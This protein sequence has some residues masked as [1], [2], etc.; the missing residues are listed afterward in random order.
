M[1]KLP[2]LIIIQESSGSTGTMSFVS[3]I[4][5]VVVTGANSTDENNLKVKTNAWLLLVVLG[6][7]HNSVVVEFIIFEVVH[8]HLSSVSKGVFIYGNV[9][10]VNIA[11]ISV[12]G[13]VDFNTP[14]PA[15]VISKGAVVCMNEILAEVVSFSLSILVNSPLFVLVDPPNVWGYSV[16]VSKPELDTVILLSFTPVDHVVSN[17]NVLTTVP[18]SVTVVDVVVPS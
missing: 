16:V 4:F 11:F 7:L 2:L 13:L 15:L 14:M 1:S 3:V 6:G 8:V 17:D 9:L 5:V 18:F 10:F 12:L